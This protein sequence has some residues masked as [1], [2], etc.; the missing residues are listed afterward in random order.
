MERPD[1][2]SSL[3]QGARDHPLSI[4]GPLSVYV[5]EAVGIYP[6]SDDVFILFRFFRLRRSCE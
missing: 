2:V 5:F 6:P 4:F 3:L 1:N